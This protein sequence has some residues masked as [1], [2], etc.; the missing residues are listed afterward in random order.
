LRDYLRQHH[1]DD[2]RTSM[3]MTPVSALKPDTDTRAGTLRP[4][5]QPAPEQRET[6]VI[7]RLAEEAGYSLPFAVWGAYIE[8]NPHRVVGAGAEPKLAITDVRNASGFVTAEQNR[9]EESQESDTHA[10]RI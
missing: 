3:L 9:T 7:H 2:V 4:Y 6:V 8:A 1:Q 10:V 5:G